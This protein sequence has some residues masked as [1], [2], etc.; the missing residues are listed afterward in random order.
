MR[1]TGAV[2]FVVGFGLTAL[3]GCGIVSYDQ[4]GP[5]SEAGR[6][7]SGSSNAGDARSG[8][9]TGGGTK[10]GGSDAGGGGDTNADG[11]YCDVLK[12]EPPVSID[13]IDPNNTEGFQRITA[14]ADKAEA[15]AP[16]EI[17]PQWQTLS[18]MLEAYEEAFTDLENADLTELEKQGVEAEKAYA[19]VAADAKER[20]DVDL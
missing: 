13:A 14:A 19:V 3:V 5:A 4:T 1:R 2:L 6:A 7:N 12:N 8:D 10:A 9:A 11:A 15:A 17:K 18:S 16:A 20:C